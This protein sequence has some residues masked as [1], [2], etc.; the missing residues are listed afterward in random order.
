MDPSSND[1]VP[2]PKKKMPNNKRKF[3]TRTKGGDKNPSSNANASIMPVAYAQQ[4]IMTAVA[5]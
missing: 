2:P 4:S 5:H 1:D 3:G